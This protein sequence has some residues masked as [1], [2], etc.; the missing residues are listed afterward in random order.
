MNELF[1]INRDEQG[2]PRLESARELYTFLEVKQQFSDWFKNRVI[3]YGFQEGVDYVEVEGFTKNAVKPN[4]DNFHK[5]MKVSR[6]GPVA[7]D[8]A[9]TLDMAKELA[10]VERT[11]K[12]KQARQYFI[13]AEKTLRA[14]ADQQSTALS[15]EQMLL[16]LASQQTQLLTNQQDQISQ[17]R[18]D[19]ESLMAGQR[20]T[21]SRGNRGGQQLGL[22]GMP[23]AP[24]R[25]NPANLRQTINH[26]VADYCGYHNA[27]T[28]ETYNYLYKRMQQVYGVDVRRLIRLSGESYLDAIER[29]GHLDRL[30][31]LVAAELHY[32]EE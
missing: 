25:H 24:M 11:D 20:P 2:T 27:T 15:T 32:S 6:R 9:I 4:D 12:G 1:K 17:L 29:Y 10:M 16:Q 31:S 7:T 8:Y 14:I 30:Y 18:S 26:R 23:T 22:P 13:D 19:V 3:K 28:Q 21:R 5:P